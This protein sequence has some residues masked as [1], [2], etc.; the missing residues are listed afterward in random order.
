MKRKKS[1]G[2]LLI[3][4]VLLVISATAVFAGS[5]DSD[6]KLDVGAGMFTM[7]EKSGVNNKDLRVF[8]YR[9]SG[10]TPDKPI[11]IVQHGVQRNAE[12]Y[13]D[14]WKQD[15]D[16]YNLLVICPEFSEEKY[17]GV[18]YYNIANV[19]GSD[20]N[21]KLQ[22][23]NQWI[24]PVSDRVFDQV[25]VRSGAT[26]DTFILF[27]H[28]AGAQMVHR[29]IFFDKE[30]KAGII[31]AA[32]AGWYTMPDRNIA[33]PYGIEDMPLTDED[34]AGAFAKQVII[35]LGEKDNN[36]NHKVLRHTQQADNQGMNRLERGRYFYN[37]AKAKAEE[38][39]VP[40][41]WQLITVPRVGHNDAGMA[42]AAARLIG[43]EQM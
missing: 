15:A 10:W 43:E 32:N 21:G 16:K 13:R 18:R 5:K 31:I 41:K 30:T 12:A 14:S 9:P 8:Y 36:P 3:V 19:V 4:F 1:R 23:R 17:P 35:L 37:A 25:R 40:F 33:F 7:P 38:L 24:F 11:V 29:Y 28:S 27:G 26:S 42:A 39:G 2:F 22:P 6:R 20:E 34:L